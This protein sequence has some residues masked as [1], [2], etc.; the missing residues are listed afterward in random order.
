MFDIVIPVEST[1]GGRKPFIRTEKLP[2][3]LN[4]FSY[5]E[6][7]AGKT[8]DRER[9]LQLKFEL[10]GLMDKLVVIAL[11][12][13]VLDL[14]NEKYQFAGIKTEVEYGY[15]N[16]ASAVVIFEYVAI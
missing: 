4:D 9:S 5:Y 3:P 2:Y 16:E 14:Y 7:V 10:Y 13:A 12:E 6:L 8:Y 1:K 11:S 15:Y